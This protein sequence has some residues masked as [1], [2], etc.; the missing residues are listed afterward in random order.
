MKTTLSSL[1]LEPQSSP[2]V[3][4]SKSNTQR[5]THHRKLQ[6]DLVTLATC[7]GNYKGNRYGIFVVYVF[8][9]IYCIYVYIYI[10]CYMLCQRKVSYA[11]LK[12]VTRSLD[13][14]IFQGN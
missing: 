6:D 9:T 12:R 2:S 1:A 13:Q 14:D 10:S 11:T 8:L 3:L 7:D 5:T 4:K